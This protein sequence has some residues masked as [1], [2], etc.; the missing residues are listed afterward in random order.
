MPSLSSQHLPIFP[1][2]LTA[3]PGVVVSYVSTLLS[4]IEVRVDW[5]PPSDPITIITSYQ[6]T[7][8]EYEAVGN[9]ETVILDGNVTSYIIQNLGMYLYKNLHDIVDKWL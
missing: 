8:S 6:V 4:D 1:N 5:L 3:Q 7:Y 2:T 9:V